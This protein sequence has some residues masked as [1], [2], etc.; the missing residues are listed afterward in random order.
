M[1]QS[2]TRW[3]KPSEETTMTLGSR[4]GGIFGTLLLTL[5]FGFVVV[6]LVATVVVRNTTVRSHQTEHGRSTRIE[7]PLGAADFSDSGT[8]SPETV[9]IPVYPGAVRL[10]HHTPSISI[11]PES[12]KDEGFSY[13]MA[14]YRTDDSV[15][16]VRRFYSQQSPHWIFSSDEGKQSRA[17]FTKGGYKRIVIVSR[18]SGH[19]HIAL[20]STGQAAAN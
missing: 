20:A 5:I 13:V 8:F 6:Y 15:E 2:G 1:E 18:I 4:R 3:R 11:E 9:G 10:D 14:E 17:E 7:T 16:S 12:R 19:T